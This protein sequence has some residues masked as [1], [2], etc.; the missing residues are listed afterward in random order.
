MPADAKSPTSAASPASDVDPAHKSRPPPRPNRSN[1][2]LE[3]NPFEQSFSGHDRPGA[4]SDK[5]PQSPTTPRRASF[6]HTTAAPA[7]TTIPADSGSSDSG[8]SDQDPGLAEGCVKSYTPVRGDTCLG[9]AAKFGITLDHFYDMNPCIDDLCHN[10][11]ITFPYCVG[12]DT[13]GAA[14]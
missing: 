5:K 10:L 4:P 8:D 11:Q 1:F 12:L 3:P 2:D 7:A 13:D 6:G 14:S 9:V